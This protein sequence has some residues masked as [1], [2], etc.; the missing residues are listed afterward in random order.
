MRNHFQNNKK[1]GEFKYSVGYWVVKCVFRCGVQQP[2][3][4]V[5]I[6]RFA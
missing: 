3:I 5:D 2:D 4:V 1:H 6:Q